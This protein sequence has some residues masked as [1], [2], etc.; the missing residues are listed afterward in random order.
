MTYEDK[1]KTARY[2][3]R[4]FCEFENDK[5]VSK[6]PDD[7]SWSWVYG[8]AKK[9]SLTA[10]FFAA[11]SDY[12][13]AEAPAELYLDLIR[14]VA[15][16]GAKHIAQKA[17][18]EKL[19]KLFTENKISFMPLKGF[20]IKELYKSPELR[21]M[22][23][24]DI[25]VGKEDFDSA[26]NIIRNLGFEPESSCEVHDSFK[27]SPFVEIELHR[28]LH[29][30]VKDYTMEQSVAREENPYH[31]LMSEEDFLIFLLH[32]AK[33]HDETGGAGIRSIFDFYLIF[34]KKNYDEKLLL[35][36]IA[37]E[38]LLDFYKRLKSLIGFWFYNEALTPELL[39]FELYTVTGGT[40]GNLENAYLRKTKKKGSVAFF[41]ERLF[42]PFEIMKTRYP[43]LKKCPILLPVFYI[44]RIFSSLFDGSGKKNIKA[45]R[46][47]GK[48]KKALEKLNSQKD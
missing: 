39:E 36:R 11:L 47:A 23:D 8:M 7:I 2:L 17:E 46:G 13:K 34:K 40:Y 44:V 26:A 20:L 48:K 30:D 31:R 10:F 16:C 25:F 28:I 18:L 6:K 3:A 27:K 22:T 4:V 24:I 29:L 38:N 32:H 35:K 42:P 19:S 14:D 37:K 45:L 43:V 1:I 9:H 41:F 15:I 5:P 21:E 33:K 12:V